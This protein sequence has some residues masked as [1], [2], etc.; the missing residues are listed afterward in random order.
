MHRHKSVLICGASQKITNVTC[1]LKSGLQSYIC[2][3]T[4]VRVLSLILTS[5]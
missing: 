1:E 2:G 5:F 3:S 4:C